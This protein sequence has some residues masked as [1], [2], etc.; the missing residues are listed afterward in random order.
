MC[1]AV[2]NLTFWAH[3]TGKFIQS[4]YC[5]EYSL[6]TLRYNDILK[7]YLDHVEGKTV[8][9]VFKAEKLLGTKPL[10]EHIESVPK[11]PASRSDCVVIFAL[12]PV[13]WFL[14]VGILLVSVTG[15]I[16]SILLLPAM[17]V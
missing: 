1:D 4:S 8:F 7:A 12:V 9:S 6:C 16:I 2:W 15:H 10:S 14:F 5:A 17:L 11:T 3:Y 13:F